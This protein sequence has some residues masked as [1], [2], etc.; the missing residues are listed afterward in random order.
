AR[1]TRQY[2]FDGM[3]HMQASLHPFVLRNLEAG[4]G[5]GWPQD[6]LSRFPDWR[7]DPKGEFTLDTQKLLKIMER[8]WNEAF[9]NVLD[10]THR[11]IVNELIEV[12]NKLAHDGKFTYDDAERALDS[13]RRLL[14]AVSAGEAAEQISKMRESILRTK[15]T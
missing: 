2:V 12:R 13:M 1:S 15:F 4:M 7:L 8:C 9:R 5:K 11:S 3:E 10:R 14:E 6:V